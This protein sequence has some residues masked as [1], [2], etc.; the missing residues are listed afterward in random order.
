MGRF[1]RNESSG[2]EVFF[3]KCMFGGYWLNILAKGFA[4]LTK[5]GGELQWQ[6]TQPYHVKPLADV[7]YGKHVLILGHLIFWRNQSWPCWAIHHIFHV[8][9]ICKTTV[10]LVGEAPIL[11]KS[12]PKASLHGNIPID[13]GHQAPQRSIDYMMANHKLDEWSLIHE[14]LCPSTFCAPWQLDGN[15][16]AKW[17]IFRCKK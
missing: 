1:S 12:P 9:G 6:T 5:V 16:N 14:E 17:S 11:N 13:S 15:W 8:A 7:C 2:A 4:L 3:V 10:I